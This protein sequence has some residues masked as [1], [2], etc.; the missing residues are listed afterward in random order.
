MC[1]RGGVFNLLSTSEIADLMEQEVGWHLPPKSRDGLARMSAARRERSRR[2]LERVPVL[3]WER[4]EWSDCERHRLQ[5]MELS[6][7]FDES[8]G[9]LVAVA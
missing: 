3:C 5:Q 4:R 8:P 6:G 1:E 2:L 7:R 9:Q